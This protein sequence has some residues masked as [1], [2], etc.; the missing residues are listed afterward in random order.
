MLV[1]NRHGSSDSYRYGFNGKDNE[2]RRGSNSYDF[3][4]R[5]LDQGEENGLRLMQWRKNTL[6]FYL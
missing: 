4:A 6:V 1:P 3:G 2:L 5:M